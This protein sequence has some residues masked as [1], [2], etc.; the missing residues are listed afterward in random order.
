MF[1]WLAMN[2]DLRSSLWQKLTQAKGLG[3][4]AAGQTTKNDGLPRQGY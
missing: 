3:C 2:F 1:K 4:C